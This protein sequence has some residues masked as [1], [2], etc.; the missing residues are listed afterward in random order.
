MTVMTAN[1]ETLVSNPSYELRVLVEDVP[2]PTYNARRSGASAIKVFEKRTVFVLMTETE[3]LGDKVVPIQTIELYEKA[4]DVMHR[5]AVQAMIAASAP[6]Q[7]TSWREALAEQ[8]LG[9]IEASIN[10]EI[11]AKLYQNPDLRPELMT[12]LAQVMA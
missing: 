2:N 12:L 10:A 5:A 3:T 8:G 6:L 1:K 9:S 7:A 11:L 4:I